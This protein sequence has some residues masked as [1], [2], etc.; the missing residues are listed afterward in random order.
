MNITL[1]SIT[2]SF[3][4]MKIK[5]IDRYIYSSLILPSIF[6]ISIFTFILMLN[7]VM[8]VMERLFASDLPF[9]SIID[10]F[11]YAV[12]GILVQ[13][14][15][16]GAFLGVMLV[17]G[18]LSETNELIAME[19]SG[20]GLFRIIRPAFIFGVILTL[21][22]LGLEIYVNPRALENIN[23]QTKAMLATKPSSLTEEK[24]FLTNAESGF[25]FYIDEVDNEK[26]NAKNF[27]ILNKQGENPYPVIFLA[28]SATFDPGV[29]VLKNVKGYS[30]DKEGNSQVA[31][32]YKEQE[33][34]ISTFFKDKNKE[35]KKSRSE[36]NIK[37]LKQFHDENI[38]IPEM[39]EAA[40]KALVEIYQRLIGPLASTLLCWLG[41]LLS[42][43]HR[44]SGRGISF[45]ISLIV[46]FAYIAVVNYAKIMVLKN[47]IPANIAMWVPNTIL[48][49]LCV[50]FSIK[51]YR[52]N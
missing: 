17:Y 49:I 11:L 14:I 52:R 45:G 46:I 30:F 31:A 4:L 35:Y 7:V 23:A 1:R 19:G 50:Y 28:E 12:P 8:E 39:R 22:G 25:G 37:E 41:V 33:I 5:I 27:L 2:I 32:E 44:R 42:V 21:I 15:P 47:N 16:M 18:G 13:T 36:M 40:L 38:K 48:L 10:Y 34:P 26:A 9:I 6:G 51:K 24:I 43:G 3:I 20:I 29:I